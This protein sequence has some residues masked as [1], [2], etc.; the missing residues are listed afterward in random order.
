MRKPGFAAPG[1]VPRAG[2]GVLLALPQSAMSRAVDTQGLRLIGV[3]FVALPVGAVAG[4]VLGL[5]A[6]RVLRRQGL[7]DGRRATHRP[8]MLHLM[9]PQSFYWTCAT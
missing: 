6:E 7:D 4:A 5:I 2:V 8:A 1:L 3:I 9:T